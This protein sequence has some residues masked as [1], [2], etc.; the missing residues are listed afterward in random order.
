MGG[1][2]SLPVRWRVWA[3]IL[4]GGAMANLIAIVALG[5]QYSLI[6]FA[7]NLWLRRTLPF[8]AVTISF[9]I[10]AS[11][12][13]AIWHRKNLHTMKQWGRLAA[14]SILL[15]S[16]LF[17]VDFLIALLNGQSNPLHF[18][19]GL[20]GLPLTLFICPG[21]TI[22]CLAGLVRAFYISRRADGYPPTEQNAP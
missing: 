9:L 7:A 4:G 2:S 6:V 13:V 5:L 15:A 14:V 21:G 20:L 3:S 1:C 11:I 19:G 16:A 17:G 12:G 8:G 18:P 10:L 22:I